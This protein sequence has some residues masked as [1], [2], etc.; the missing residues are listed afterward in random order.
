[1]TAAMAYPG[2]R[3][4]SGAARP[5]RLFLRFEIGADRYVMAASDIV[6]IL[7][8]TPL[9]QLPAAPAWVAGVLLYGAR[10]VPVVDVAALA[11][12][13]AARAQAS[14]RLIVVAY[15]VT[16]PAGARLLGLLLERANETVH[17]F[18][19]EFLPCGLDNRDAPYLGPVKAEPEGMVQWVD[20]D[21]LLPPSVRERLFLDLGQQDPTP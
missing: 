3:A 11:T 1:M 17:Y 4:G 19:D 15:R 18:P 7:P 10:P 13:Q 16:D 14:T 12:G 9:K 5:R 8:L 6:Q 20:V 21:Q 2:Q